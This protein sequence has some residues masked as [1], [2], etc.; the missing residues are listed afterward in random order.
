MN[1][2]YAYIDADAVALVN[3][4]LLRDPARRPQRQRRRHTNYAI[5]SPQF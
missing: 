3:D 2:Y 1:I 4:I 5:F